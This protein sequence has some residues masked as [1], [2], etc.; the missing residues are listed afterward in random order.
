[1]GVCG[2]TII[3]MDLIPRTTLLYASLY[4]YHPAWYMNKS[5]HIRNVFGMNE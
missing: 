3:F 2:D 1:M 5:E 4:S